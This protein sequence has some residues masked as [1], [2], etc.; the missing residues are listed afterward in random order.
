[1]EAL[2]KSPAMPMRQCRPN[3]IGCFAAVWLG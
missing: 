3:T 1:M 2:A